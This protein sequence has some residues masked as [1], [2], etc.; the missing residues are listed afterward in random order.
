MREAT[1]RG[2]IDGLNSKVF[3]SSQRK[4]RSYFPRVKYG[5]FGIGVL[6]FI[7][8]PGHGYKFRAREIG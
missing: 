5:G 4:C 6:C 1:M 3:Y 2:F 8:K 7:C